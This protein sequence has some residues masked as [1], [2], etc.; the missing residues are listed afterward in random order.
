MEQRLHGLEP[1]I[2]LFVETRNF[3]QI[4]D[5]M[6]PRNERNK[7]T[8]AIMNEPNRS[9]AY[10]EPLWIT[11]DGKQAGATVEDFIM[12]SRGQMML[13]RNAIGASN[14]QLLFSKVDAAIEMVATLAALSVIVPTKFAFD[15]VVR[16]GRST[17]HFYEGA[18]EFGYDL[19][20]SSASYIHPLAQR[21]IDYEI[22]GRL[23]AYDPF[24]VFG[25][26]EMS[27]LFGDELPLALVADWE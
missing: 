11:V 19:I 8:A 7:F 23:Y 2:R 13:L 1:G 12:F 9:F 14:R 24:I 17:A 5:P 16:M 10:L 21:Q 22:Y 18:K 4:P 6:I 15:V 27:E 26:P 3:D 20:R 25:T